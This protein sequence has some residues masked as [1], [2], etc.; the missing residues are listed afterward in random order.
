[1]LRREGIKSI[2]FGM[3]TLM[4]ENTDYALTL[5]RTFD[6]PAAKVYACWTP[7]S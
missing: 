2:A 5:T 4:T 1:M 6:A 7:S 3:E